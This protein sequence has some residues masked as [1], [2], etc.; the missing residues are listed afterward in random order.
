MHKARSYNPQMEYR[1]LGKTGLMI[2][3]VAL[4]GHWKKLPYK[5]GSDGIVDSGFAAGY[6]DAEPCCEVV[7]PETYNW[8]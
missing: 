6:T 2:S 1:R 3:A 5:V 7:R 8:R 4:E